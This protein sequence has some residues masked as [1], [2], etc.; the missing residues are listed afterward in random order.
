M[1]SQIT[2]RILHDFKDETYSVNSSEEIFKIFN[3]FNSVKTI[4]FII[5]KSIDETNF[6]GLSISKNN[7]TLEYFNNKKQNFDKLSIQ[8]I[9]QSKFYIKRFINEKNKTETLSFFE[10]LKEDNQIDEKAKYE[11]WKL[12]SKETF[13]VEKRKDILKNTLIVA[14]TVLVFFLGRYLYSGEYKFL[15]QDTIKTSAKIHKI[16]W[17][18]WGKNY[19]Y[20]VVYFNYKVNNKTFS[21]KSKI[22]NLTQKGN[23]TK[24][25]GDYVVL[26]I[27][28]TKPKNFK[29]LE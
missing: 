1:N 16:G 26:K 13:K 19:Y 4:D 18:H 6:E 27:S 2:I 8:S 9:D 14:S 11:Q 10:K 24:K 23:E 5:Y 25:V 7:N 15:G 17:F 12:K 29:L 21:N 20:Q 28:K 22:G 3:H